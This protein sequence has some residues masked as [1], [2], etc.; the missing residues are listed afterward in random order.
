[1]K[2]RKVERKWII[3]C[4]VE[5]RIGDQLELMERF[6]VGPTLIDG[7]SFGGT[8]FWWDQ[9][10]L[11]PINFISSP[12]KRQSPLILEKMRVKIGQKYLDKIVHISFYYYYFFVW[13]TL[14]WRNK[15]GLSTIFFFLFFLLGFTG[16]WFFFFINMMMCISA[17]THDSP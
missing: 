15:C 10:E 5:G 9:L 7:E 4:L 14:T 12:S 11:G 8:N 17:W 13:A 6:L 3:G 2:D 1:M 16:R